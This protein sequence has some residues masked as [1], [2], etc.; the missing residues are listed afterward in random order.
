[1]IAFIR[2][3]LFETGEDSVIIEVQGIAYE[4]IMHRRAIAHLPQRGAMVKVFTHFQ[5]LENEFKLYGFLEREEQGLFKT[6]LGV[7]GMGAKGAMNILDFMEAEQF[8]RAIASQDEKLLT[9]VPGIGKKSAQRLFFE[10]KDKIKAVQFTA[11]GQRD[12]PGL[13][14]VMEALETL[15]YQRSEVFPLIMELKAQG[16]M[17]DRVEDNIKSVLRARALQMKK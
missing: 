1:M 13:N 16:N 12:E 6:L 14:D 3:S 11:P 7:S 10:L 2:G 9:Q 5:V 17:S 8:Y 15:G 4:L